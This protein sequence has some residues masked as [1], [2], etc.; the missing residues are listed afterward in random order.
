VHDAELGLEMASRTLVAAC[1]LARAEWITETPAA[2]LGV[3]AELRR[4]VAECLR[5]DTLRIFHAQTGERND[6]CRR[7]LQ[8]LEFLGVEQ[9]GLIIVEGVDRF[10]GQANRET[11]EA[12]VTAW[13]Q[14]AERNGCAVLWMCPRRPGEP[15]HQAKFQRMAHRFSGL[16]RLHMTGDAARYDVFYWFAH[17][18][19]M[20]HKSFRLNSDSGGNWL[21][22]ERDTSTID[23]ADTPLDEDDVFIMHAALPDGRSAPNDWRVFDTSEQMCVALSSAHACT[24]IFHYNVGSPIE[25]L[26]H[27]IFELRRLIGPYLKIAVKKS[28][29][30]LRHSNELL[31]LSVGANLLIPSDMGYARMLN[32]LKSIQGHIFSRALPADFEVASASA[33][34]V[35]QTGY[36]APEDFKRVVADVMVQTRSPDVHNA[37]IRL[38]ITKGLGVL[39]TLRN[40]TMRRSGDLFTADEDSVYV[41]LSACEEQDISATLDR[42]FRLPVSVIFSDQTCFLSTVDIAGA[43]AEFNRRASEKH[44]EDFSSSLENLFSA[45]EQRISLYAT[46]TAPIQPTSRRAFTAVPH[47]LQLRTTQE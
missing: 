38:Y 19:L 10:A 15:S 25:K 46:A 16:A 28:G 41:F 4:E 39:E 8:E 31:L 2:Y 32:Q 36:L 11:W 42:V 44:Y 3:H 1:V 13:Q 35:T 7:M 27:H 17:E 20:T 30:R 21:V 40:C 12:D 34:F 22:V 24:V 9:G 26:A 5:K 14:W 43:L 23:A 29:G 37:L 6:L 18:W 47:V 45:D 33:N